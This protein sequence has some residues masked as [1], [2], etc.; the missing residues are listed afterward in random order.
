MSLWMLVFPWRNMLAEHREAC[1]VAQTRALLP[2]LRAQC[3][4]AAAQPEL[5][6]QVPTSMRRH[7]LSLPGL[8][9]TA[10]AIAVVLLP[11]SRSLSQD[12]QRPAQPEFCVARPTAY[13]LCSAV[14]AATADHTCMCTIMGWVLLLVCTLRYPTGFYIDGTGTKL[15]NHPDFKVRI[16]AQSSF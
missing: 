2:V 10:T 11:K 12:S 14:P 8:W 6:A 9:A 3:S 13:C 16:Q 4:G 1:P 15:Q 5:S 7:L